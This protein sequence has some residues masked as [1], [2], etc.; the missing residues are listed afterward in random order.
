M[1]KG[2]VTIDLFV[3]TENKTGESANIRGIKKVQKN[4][5]KNNHISTEIL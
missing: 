1:E 2:K 3:D 4:Q 5:M